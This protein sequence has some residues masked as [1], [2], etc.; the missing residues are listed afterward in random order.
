M[1]SREFGAEILSSPDNPALPSAWIFLS[2]E[3]PKGLNPWD[4][5]CRVWA[6]IQALRSSVPFA[7]GLVRNM[8]QGTEQEPHSECSC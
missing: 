5:L 8:R 6:Q 7:L 3:S 1:V 4:Q 2:A